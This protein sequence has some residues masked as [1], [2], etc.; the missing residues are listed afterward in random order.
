MGRLMKRNKKI[1]LKRIA[2]DNSKEIKILI[3]PLWTEDGDGCDCTL[4]IS[5]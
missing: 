1:L 2:Y 4:G 5:S 3:L